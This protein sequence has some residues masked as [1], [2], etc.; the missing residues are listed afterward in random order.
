M[1]LP[2]YLHVIPFPFCFRAALSP[3]FLPPTLYTIVR[4]DS[5]CLRRSLA[6]CS[7]NERR[8]VPSNWYVVEEACQVIYLEVAA[9]PNFEISQAI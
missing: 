6:L 7:E 1:I 2:V 3:P 8:E 9:H 4:Q 5:P